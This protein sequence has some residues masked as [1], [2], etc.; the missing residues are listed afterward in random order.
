MISPLT[1]E[2]E[3]L[4]DIA[5][6]FWTIAKIQRSGT[7]AERDTF[8]SLRG[9]QLQSEVSVAAQSPVNNRLPVKF[10]S[11]QA[12][13]RDRYDW[14]Y[15]QRL[16]VANPDFGS[17]APDAIRPQDRTLKVFHSNAKRLEDSGEAAPYDVVLRPWQV[18]DVRI[19]APAEI[20][21]SRSL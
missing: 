7:P 12:P 20:D 3:S 15:S 2:Y 10:T 19:T 16:T 6:D 9:F 5:P 17:N 13:G 11:W 4:C 18:A 21:L 8:G 14:N 1:M